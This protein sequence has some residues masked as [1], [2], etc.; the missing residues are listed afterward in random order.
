[1]GGL[2]RITFAVKQQGDEFELDPAM[3]EHLREMGLE[4]EQ[5]EMLVGLARRIAGGGERPAR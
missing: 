3:R 2:L 4:D 5:M 1:M